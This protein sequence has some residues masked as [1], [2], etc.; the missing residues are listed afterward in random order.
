MIKQFN[1]L[2]KAELKL[3]P[4]LRKGQA[5][6]NVLAKLNSKWADEIRGNFVID[7]FYNDDVIPEFKK[8]LSKKIKEGENV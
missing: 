8:W 7:P 2:V 4:E 6:F 3:Y 1:K 5:M